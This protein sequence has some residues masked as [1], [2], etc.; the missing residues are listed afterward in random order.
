MAANQEKSFLIIGDGKSA[1]MVEQKS[2]EIITRPIAASI[3][4][5]VFAKL[6]SVSNVILASD[7]KNCV[8]TELQTRGYK[9]TAHKYRNYT[10][11]YLRMMNGYPDNL[12]FYNCK[13]V[14]EDK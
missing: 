6:A 2:D 14:E 8:Y 11:K 5:A 3:V 4:D 1:R 10:K 7:I 13:S 12:Q 9:E